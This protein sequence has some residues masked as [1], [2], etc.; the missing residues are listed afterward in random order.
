M[1]LAAG[2]GDQVVASIG[3]WRDEPALTGDEQLVLE[4]ADAVCDGHVPQVLA[5]SA[6]ERFGQ[7]ATSSLS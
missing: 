2:V 4:L 1:A 6:C 7:S 3:H 5:E